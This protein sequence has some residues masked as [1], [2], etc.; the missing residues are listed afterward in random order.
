[1]P[2]IDQW[3]D[4]FESRPVGTTFK[5]CFIAIILLAILGGVA[6]TISYFGGWFS[7]SAA[8][9]KEE[10]GPRAL[11]TKYEWFKDTAAALDKKQ[12]DINLF[13]QRKAG[14]EA[15]LGP[16]RS[17]WDRTDKEQWAQMDAEMIG[18]RASYKTLAAQYNAEMA[19]FNYRFANVGRLPEGATEVLPREFRAYE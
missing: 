19:K 14:L 4:D 7:E 11:L 16:N 10:F 3:A 2:K 5:G 18:V 12:A 13:T 9:M 6:G 15:I 8:V 17:E 1:M